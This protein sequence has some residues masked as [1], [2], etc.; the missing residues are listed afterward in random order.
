M[1]ARIIGTGSCI[2]ACLFVNNCR[3]GSLPY[4]EFRI[5]GPYSARNLDIFLIH[6]KDRYNAANLLTLDEAVSAKKII[7][8]ETGSVNELSVENLS[9]QP[10]FIQAG[11]IVKGGRQDRT[12]QDD[13]VITPKSG[14][15][16]VRSFC[17]E[18]GRWSG[19]GNEAAAMFGSAKKQLASRELKLAARSAKSQAEVWENVARVQEKLSATMGRSVHNDVSRSSLQ[20]TLENGDLARATKAY[21]DTI[22]AKTA[23]HDEVVGFAYAV[24]GALSAMDR[25][26]SRHLFA[27][28][29]PKLLDACVTEALS[30]LDTATTVKRPELPEVVAWARSAEKGIG[31]TEAINRENDVTKKDNDGSV[32]FE[33]YTKQQPG[34][35]VH[36]SVLK[37]SLARKSASPIQQRRSVS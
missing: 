12:M 36:T 23:Q 30:E 24:N 11:D 32:Q 15:V 29:W 34:K 6:G 2:V 25:Y 13:A 14:K 17:V 7:V 35:C 19:R 9:D 31:E 18:S 1:F 3:S 33:T 4:G 28:Q 22:M 5:S 26:G 21:I 16:A 37:K 8:H 10:V 27:K 20:L